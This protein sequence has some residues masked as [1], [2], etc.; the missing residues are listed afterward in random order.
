VVLLAI[1]A[2]A[3]AALAAFAA[4]LALLDWIRLDPVVLRRYVAPVIEET[5]KA[6]WVVWVI[7]RH[8]VG[9]MVDAAI[10]GFAVG[11]GFALAENLHYARALAEPDALLWLVRGLGTAVMHGC[12]TAILGIVSKD[13]TDRHR[14]TALAWL[15]PGLGI[16]ILVHSAFNHL[17]VNPLMTV[18]IVLGTL[19]LLLVAVFER[20][21]RATRAWLGHGMDAEVEVL[22]MIHSGEIQGTR[23]GRYLESLKTRFPGPVVADMLCLLQIRL[24]LALRAKGMLLA[25]QAGVELPIDRDVR[26]NLAEMRFLEKSIGPTGRIAMLPLVRDSARD[27]WQIH[28][29]AERA[30]TREGSA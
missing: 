24:E 10:Q 30:G 16:A 18:A 1:G 4:N 17:T 20:S 11:A 28:H 12:T 27:L 9:F 19:P 2:G 15:L 3:V 8:R 26:A 29:L 25:R 14:S 5:L 6:L 21:E 13:L 23:I 7:R 22:E